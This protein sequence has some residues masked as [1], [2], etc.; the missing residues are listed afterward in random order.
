M[1]LK[2]P[3]LLLKDAA[4]GSKSSSYSVAWCIILDCLGSTAK[5]TKILPWFLDRTLREM[6]EFLW[7]I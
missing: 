6:D 5:N 7:E 4:K 2:C 1:C 3:N